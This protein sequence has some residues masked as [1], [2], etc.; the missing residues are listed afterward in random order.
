MSRMQRT[1][2]LFTA[3]ITLAG[4]AW[5]FKVTPKPGSAL[6]IQTG[7]EMEWKAPTNLP[8]GAEYHLLREDPH[9]QG[10]QAIA[11]FPSK[12]AIPEHTHTVDE[13]IVVLRGKLLLKAGDIEKTLK[14]GDYA[15]IPAHVPHEMRA[16]TWFRKVSILTTTNAP[17]DLTY[18]KKTP[19]AS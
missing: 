3:L 18:T 9:T 2:R 6:I 8:T 17:Y 4:A 11:R 16:D 14:A 1:T 10:I 7:S 15:V 19:S 5:G 13:T 12:S